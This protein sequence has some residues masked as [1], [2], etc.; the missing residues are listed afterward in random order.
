MLL[1][2]LVK[3]F[4]TNCNTDEEQFLNIIESNNIKLNQR[5]LI[6]I[7]EEKKNINNTSSNNGSSNNRS[8]N[9]GS[10]NNMSSNNETSN[11][12]TSNNET[13][14]NETSNKKTT[15]TRG[16]GRPRKTKDLVEESDVILEVELITLDG[17]DYYKTRENVLICED[18]SIEG[19][20]S[21][22]KVLRVRS[23]M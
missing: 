12:E 1:V 2:D 14:N 7:K 19:I 17:K 11:N 10:S 21:G 18:L 23:P 8:S 5:L 9:N 3:L 13:S 4:S 15:G 6:Q 20:L 22:D 16:R